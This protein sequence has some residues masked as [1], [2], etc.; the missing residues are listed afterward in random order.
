[1]PHIGSDILPFA[2]ARL[3][4]ELLAAGCEIRFESRVEDVLS[5][6]GRVTGVLLDDGSRLD[7]DRV[8]LA[9]GNSARELFER[10][11]RDGRVSIEAKPFAIGFRAEHPQGLI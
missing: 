1:K 11:A 5:A 9:P 6:D 10:F 2:V 3:R 7:S 8:V 4:D